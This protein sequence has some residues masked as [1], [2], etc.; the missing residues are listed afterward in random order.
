MKS[1]P[2]S[3]RVIIPYLL[4]AVI[5]LL[6]FFPAIVAPSNQYLFGWDTM[7]IQYFTRSFY[8][9][10]MGSGQIP[11]W[12]PYQFA[13]TPFAAGVDGP[14]F[15]YPFSLLFAVLQVPQ[16]LTWFYII[17]L[18][19]AMSGMYLLMRRFVRAEAAWI[20]GIVFG[21]SGYFIP[22]ILTGTAGN[23]AAASYLPFVFW[24][25]YR[26]ME[27]Q[28]KKERVRAIIL[29]SI[30][31]CLQFL[32]GD[33]RMAVYTMM[34]V[35]CA[36]S[37]FAFWKHTVRPIFLVFIG[38][39]A[40]YLLSAVQSVP[41]L[42]FMQLSGRGKIPSYTYASNGS[43]T[44]DR[45]WELIYPLVQKFVPNTQN[46]PPFP[47]G[48]FYTGIIPLLVAC[49]GIVFFAI[50]AKRLLRNAE[51]KKILAIG[52]VF[53][54]ILLLAFWISLGSASPVDLFYLLW[55]YVPMFSFVRI[56]TRFFLLF[57]FGV[58]GIVGLTVSRIRSS[59]LTWFVI[60][61]ILVELFPFSRSFLI[62]SGTP[63]TRHNAELTQI[64]K[65]NDMFRVHPNYF[66]TE[67]LGNSMDMNAASHYKYFS[68]QGYSP[69]ILSSYVDFYNAAC[70]T[71]DPN[72]TLGMNQLPPMYTP[73]EP[74]LDFLNVKYVYGRGDLA[75]DTESGRFKLVIDNPYNWFRL[76][77]NTTAVPRFFMAPKAVFYADTA[78]VTKALASRNVDIHESILLVDSAKAAT[79]PVEKSAC[80]TSLG[81]VHVVS[82]GINTIVLATDTRCD[83]YLASSE[84]M[85]P[86]W[87][88]TIDGKSVSILTGNL[89][90]RTVF[91]PAGAHTI[92]M[93]YVPRIFWIGGAISVVTC[94]LLAVWCGIKRK[95]L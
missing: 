24:G 2:I 31:L 67:R 8:H 35:G 19:I 82:Y 90:F 10:F 16:A 86:G 63:D 15:F 75:P 47:E 36:S 94:A 29:A 56:P 93:T 7:D 79:H 50:S 34:G 81:K 32:S 3:I 72:G 66:Y 38:S 60:L 71:Y 91:V 85:Y 74:C 33:Q 17:H 92:V 14:I 69:L 11:W 20:S 49:A 6:L 68:T 23:L 25:F 73:D 13:G 40:G 9:Q 53:L 37:V 51:G 70:L 83:A 59:Y 58:S 1:I 18:M 48:P 5:L 21:L 30:L 42:E 78:G 84:V 22:R 76:Y 27:K 87:N 12:N 45:L 64:L 44:P 77:E 26:V 52:I 80:L 4:Y 41:I 62:L 61:A 28:E 39:V 43:L 65:Q 54:G 88:A 57:V 95:Y 89:A 55:R 46:Y